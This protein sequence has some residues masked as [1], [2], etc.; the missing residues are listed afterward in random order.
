MIAG[1]RAARTAAG[2]VLEDVHLRT[3]RP[4]V[5]RRRRSDV[6]EHI[7]EIGIVFAEPDDA[8]ERTVTSVPIPSKF[9]FARDA[10]DR[11][12]GRATVLRS[13]QAVLFTGQRQENHRPLRA[14]A[15]R[16]R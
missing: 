14:R 5:E 13:E 16:H 2:R 10:F 12:G 1:T 6:A 4:D 7:A 9:T 8:G 15:A 11:P 3:D